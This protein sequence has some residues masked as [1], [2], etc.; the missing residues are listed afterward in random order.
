MNKHE[1]IFD[2]KSAGNNTEAQEFLGRGGQVCYCNRASDQS[3]TEAK[4]KH[5]DFI[6][7]ASRPFVL[8]KVALGAERHGTVFTAEGPLHVVDVDVEP[9]L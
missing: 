3:G 6:E 5:V 8:Q 7:V 2:P 1:N 9:Q 4:F